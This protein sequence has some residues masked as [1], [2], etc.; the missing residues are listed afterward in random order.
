MAYDILTVIAL[1][2]LVVAFIATS[3]MVKSKHRSK[4]MHRHFPDSWLPCLERLPLY[5][6]LPENLQDELRARIMI[7]L[8]E[9]DFEGCGGLEVDDNMKV[10]IAAL[11]CMLLL[12]KKLDYY[13][14]LNSVLVYPDAY[15]SPKG[16]SKIGSNQI[17]I[18]TESARLGESWLHGDLIVSWKQIEN[19]AFNENSHSNVILHEFAH[20]IDQMNGAADCM[21]P[22]NNREDFEEWERTVPRE[23]ADLQRRTEFGIPDVIDRYG[24]SNPAEFFAVTTETF[25]CRPID[26]RHHRPEL[27][28]QF[29]N[30]YRL[31]PGSWIKERG[32]QAS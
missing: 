29:R 27:Y 6:A 2:I 19:E 25:F 26:L 30:F 5:R 13:P 16:M 1:G 14:E 28:S 22:L 23:F 9:K 10:T 12:R 7:F 8:D 11:A 32:E 21:P 24:A 4:V 20:Q 31:D 3:Y 15:V 17:I 18:D